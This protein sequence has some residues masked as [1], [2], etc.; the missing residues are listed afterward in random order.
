[1]FLTIERS[2]RHVI[3]TTSSTEKINWLLGLPSGATHGVNY[4]TQNFASVVNEITEGKGANVVI[5]FVGA[6]HFEKNIEAL[7]VDGHMTM[8]AL[9]SGELKPRFE[10]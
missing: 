1:M 10:Q 4:K 7:A 8:L 5:D 3:A 9:L 2:S 6:S